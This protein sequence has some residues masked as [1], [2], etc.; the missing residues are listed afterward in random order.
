MNIGFAVGEDIIPEVFEAR[1]VSP[2]EA[3]AARHGSRREEEQPQN[4]QLT[5]PTD[6]Y[7]VRC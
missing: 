5:F 2:T 3:A 6:K 1:R 7:L 4:T